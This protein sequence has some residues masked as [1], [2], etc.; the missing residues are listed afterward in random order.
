M[1]PIDLGNYLVLENCH[2]VEVSHII[3]EMEQQIRVMLRAS[4]IEF[5]DQLIQLASTNT[6]FNGQRTWLVCPNCQTKRSVLYK[7]PI[8]GT[9]E[10]RKCMGITYS[11]QRYKGMN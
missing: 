2:K 6:N 3:K 10:C 5:E 11:K 1:N 8:S 4:Q 7:H 9:L